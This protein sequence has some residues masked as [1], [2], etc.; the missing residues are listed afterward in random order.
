MHGAI[1]VRFRGH[2]RDGIR[3]GVA[4][5]EAMLALA[6]FAEMSAHLLLQI[7]FESAERQQI[8]VLLVAGTRRSNRSWHVVLEMPEAAVQG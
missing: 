1:M 7:G 2:G 8:P 5:Q 3:D 6:T 4:G